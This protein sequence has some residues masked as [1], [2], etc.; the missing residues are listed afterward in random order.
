[1]SFFQCAFYVAVYITVNELIVFQLIDN[2]HT[3]F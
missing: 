3:P 1:L 2:H